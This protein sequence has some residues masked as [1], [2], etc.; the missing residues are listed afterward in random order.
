MSASRM[1]TAA[2]AVFLLPA[3]VIYVDDDHHGSDYTYDETPGEN[4]APE[5]EEAAA[6]CYWSPAYNDYIWWFAATIWD[7]NGFGDV[8]VVYADVYEY[9]TG[10]WV[11]SFEMYDET[12]DPMIWYSDWLEYSTWLD[13]S[14]GDYFVDITVFDEDDAWDFTQVLLD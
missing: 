1:A 9:G 4:V 13:C 5:I 14:Y 11:D 2:L 3:C 10:E 8:Q 6:G 12:D 7:A